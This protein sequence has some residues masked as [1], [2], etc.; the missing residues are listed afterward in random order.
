MMIEDPGAQAQVV[1][2]RGYDRIEPGL[3]A[4]VMNLRFPVRDTVN[5]RQVAETGRPLIVSDTHDF[6]GWIETPQ[7]A[8]VRSYL[9]GPLRIRDQVVGFF[10]LDSA[11]PGFFTS[12]HAERLMA[13]ATQAAV[14]IENAR[15]Y[16]ETR[17]RLLDQSLLYEAGQAISSTLEFNQVLETISQQLVRATNAQII[18]IQLWDRA[19]DRVSTIYQKVQTME[20]LEDLDLLEKP[21]AP[22]DYLKVAQYLRDRRN[23]SLRLNDDELDPLLRARMQEIGLLWTVEVPI[24]SRDEVLGLVRLGDTRFDR[25]LSDSEVQLIE[26]LINQAAVAMSNARLYDQ[27]LKF[28]Q[29]L[30]GRVEER[31]R[32]LARANEDLKL[33]RDQVETLFRIAS[34]LSTSL[35]LDRVLNR[36]LELVVVA[37]GATHGSILLVDPQTDVLVARAVLG[38]DRIPSMGKPT[39]FRR[40]EGLAGWAI[41]NRL[42]TIIPDVHADARWVEH[43]ERIRQYRSALVVPLSVSDDVLGAMLLLHHD[44][45]YFNDNH[46][47]M[48]SAA[49]S[50]V[51]TA[52]NNAE[53]YRYIREQAELL[54]GM[55]RAQQVEGSK[56]QA[57]LE[58]VADG[59]MVSDGSGRVILFNAAAE[60]ILGIRRDEAIGRPI[61]DMLGLYSA[62]GSKWLQQV[63]D[64]HASAE[65]RRQT[66]VLS[67][68]IDFKAEKRYVTFTVAPVTMSDEYLGSV[69]VFR[70]ITAEVEADRAKTEFI[71]TVSHELRTPM[72]SIKG[73][74]DLLL[75]GAAGAVNENQQR[76]LSVIKSNAD[77]LSILVNDLLDISRIESGRVKLELKPTAVEPLLESVVTLLHSKFEEKQLTVQVVMPSGDVPRVLADRDRVTQVLTNLVSNAYQYTPPGGSITVSAREAGEFVQIDV[78]DT[79]I[80]IALENQSKVFERFY[81][82]DDPNVNEFPGTG[83]G[84]AIVKSLVEMHEGR[85][86]LQSEVGR[87]T[88][89]SITLRAVKETTPAAAAPQLL[90]VVPEAEEIAEE[91][92]AAPDFNGQSR[93]VLVVE[94][95]KDIA[96]LI[97][98]H[99]ASHGYQVSIAGRA[100]EALKK[101]RAN[102]PSLITLDIYLPDA[103][104][105][106]LLQ[107]LKN[108]PVTRDIPVVIV[109]VMGDQREGLRLGAVDYLTKPID[110]LRLVSSVNRVLQ[111]PGKVLVVDDDRDTRDLLQT[112][113]EQ[114]GFSVVLTSSGK[115][116]LTLARQERPNLILLDLKLPGMDGYEVL[117]RL[118]NMSET[119]EIPVVIIT[120][121]LTDEELKNQ[122][123]LSLGAARF[124]TKPFAVDELVYEIGVLVTNRSLVEPVSQS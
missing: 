82:V 42:A 75:I 18:L 37:A 81:R 31:T 91:R 58:S 29:E 93:H 52:I 35:D 50:Q 10:N 3:T 30:E 14:A 63:R 118:K 119:A 56:S 15:L 95:D 99:L 114:R 124:M 45:D 88:T 92:E 108:D 48:V 122:K 40:G 89:F 60:R 73:Y 43:D 23:I 38:G 103:D 54:G 68:R 27:I 61:D 11:E 115:R 86:W 51:A 36:A 102:K 4:A 121:S 78:A 46:M 107:Q 53:L 87:G 57:I 33:E 94:D 9:C 123:L 106:E 84:L 24:V 98:R 55:L 83:L 96:E 97:G 70:D 7:T 101:A 64:W 34:E 21:F 71:S 109:S 25:S 111:G 39:P 32:E 116:A 20:G 12:T 69:S 44:L 113:L 26:T 2:S 79:G 19:T 100:D 41:V 110:P 59:V 117:Q 120:G 28:T 112:A 1:R 72:T 66:P 22:T 104:G 13:F 6:A 90:P 77:R 74:A 17:H 62:L 8:W 80:G 5:L 67:Q 16:E 65:A 49:S 76:F 85:I 105:F 47:R